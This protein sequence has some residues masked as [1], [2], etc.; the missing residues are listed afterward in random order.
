MM[1]TRYQPSLKR[2]AVSMLM[3][4]SMGILALIISLYTYRQAIATHELTSSIQL[5]SDYREKEDAILRSMIAILPNRAI[6]AMQDQSAAGYSNWRPLLWRSIFDDSINLANAR[7]S[8]SEDLKSVL[9]LDNLISA[10]TG[11]SN[12]A[13][14]DAVFRPIL[15]DTIYSDYSNWRISAGINRDLDGNF[16]PPL[17]VNDGWTNS[18]DYYFPIITNR[19][20]YGSLA[21]GDVGLDVVEYPEFN[22]LEYPQINFG[23]AE[24]G[25]D[26]VAKRNWWAFSMDLARS[27]DM[28]TGAAR[29]QREFVVSIYEIP[30]Q[31]AIS[32]SSYMSLGQF[33]N[34]EDWNSNVTISGGVF[35]GKA[36]VEG[37][38]SLS[39][40]ATRSSLTLSSGASIGGQSFT[41]SPF[42]PGLREQ[43]HITEG[44][45]FPVSMASEG[46]RVAFI[47]I[48]RGNDYYD[49][50]AH[51]VER[52][53][54][55][56]STWNDYSVG[57]LQC[58]MQL[59]ITECVSSTDSTPTEL[60]FSYYKNGVRESIEIPLLTSGVA[61]LPAGYLFAANEDQTYNFGGSVVDLAFGANGDFGYAS[62]ATGQVTFN[63]AR[64]GDPAPGYAKTGYFRP[65]YPFE[66]RTLNTGKICIVVYPQRFEDFL[67]AINADGTHINNSLVVNVD[68]STSTG[69]VNLDKPNIPCTDF[70]YGLILEESSDMTLFPNG[71]SLVTNLRLYFGD[72]F[73]T[74]ATTPPAGYTPPGDFYPPVSIFAPEKRYG[75]EIDPYAVDVS[76]QIG[77]LAS[78]DGDAIRPLD[79]TSASGDAYGSDRITINLDKISHPAELPPI[80]MMNWLITV[81]EVRNEFDD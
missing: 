52:N 22:L 42:T 50:F 11:D 57:A 6:L 14:F 70:D 24:P 25:E 29:F 73:N 48:N 27:D 38:T 7:D 9:G 21:D 17:Q 75:V 76:G 81:E 49:R 2:G 40:L 3:V 80:T 41:E 61:G 47:P 4:I 31:L 54:L 18:L 15:N 58:A 5:S 37:N 69:S 77:S 12:L 28:I 30:S 65:S 71:F 68:Y 63:V 74:V 56:R 60:R 51:S 39:A 34:G 20:L 78:E 1:K 66:I 16:P 10:N 32:A 72:D 13:N 79:S 59:D 45:F 36:V 46:G 26:F 55:S 43:Y 23:Y 35:A 67:D 8:I 62:G 53:T 19:K 33:G 44:D 64:F